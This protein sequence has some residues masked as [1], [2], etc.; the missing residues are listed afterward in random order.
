MEG[1]TAQQHAFPRVRHRGKAAGIA[2]AAAIAAVA[3]PVQ[4]IAPGVAGDW[5]WVAT[6]SYA[7]EHGLTFGERMVWTY[8]P[9]GF[10]DTWYGPRLYYG[11]VFVL[12]W[13][14]A[15][16]VQ[17]LLAGTLLAALRRSFP[18][19]LAALAA[20]VTLAFTP[21]A[22][23]ALGF[24]WC[25]LAVT[26]D[27]AAPRDRV[28]LAFP[29]ALGVLTGT[30][31]LGKLN[32]G[33]E[34][35]VLAAIAL[36]AAPRR[37]DALAFAAALLATTAAGWLGT[38]QTLADVW[39]F[40]RN[41][42]ELIAGYAAAMGRSDPSHGWTI[43]A[44]LVLAAFA[45]ALAWDAGRDARPRRR[46]ALLA[47]CA[48]YVAFAFK[49]GFVLQDAPHIEVFFG[50]M[51]VVFAVLPIR[52]SRRPLLLSGLVA[53]VLAFGAVA[54][55]HDTLR[56]LN[57]YANAKAAADQLRVVASAGRRAAITADLRTRIDALYGV[58][59]RILAAVGGR[60]TMLWPYLYGEVAWAYG[61]DLSPLP[62]LEPY[63]TYT[64]RLDRLGAQLL[65][66]EQAPPRILRASMTA[67][68][69]IDGRFATFEAP[70]AT[71]EILCR[72]RQVASEEPWQVLV[73]GADRCGAPR[74]LA[75]ATAR[76]GEPVT[77][78][79]ARAREALVLV[80]VEDAG[81]QGLERLTELLL[82]P[83]R[84]WISL[85]GTRYRLIAATAPDGLLLAAPPRADY[86][87]P[88]AMAPNPS[89][90]AVS[91]AGAEPEGE[92]RYTFVEV[93][94]RPFPANRARPAR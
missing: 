63:A 79:P 13:L 85:D 71:R 31:A 62:A 78:P 14:F 70:L 39:P 40:V 58:S 50:D 93:P 24:A 82:R 66:S 28:A 72:Y 53:G 42:V 59:P 5:G 56:T 6:L 88:F 77:V 90:I 55:G 43:P 15:A 41:G 61:L 80:Q 52:A 54:G 35:L 49:E 21:D 25:V 65:A 91:R 60:P 64:P 7:A 67:A 57:P 87:Q 47:L 18:L 46:T 76:W 81:S 27:E 68:L 84:R 48:V 11:D 73:R 17:L 19:P 69:A 94:I 29:V 33:G 89:A 20:A 75:T 51:P 1:A 83:S 4:S 74:P 37:R 44:A 26:R 86:P 36:V 38:G 23:L 12:S 22:A 30:M 34:L 3:W 32:Q 92:L 10:L 45:L 9:L 16:L 8:G 2:C